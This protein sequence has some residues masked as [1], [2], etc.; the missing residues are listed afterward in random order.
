MAE[1]EVV[2]WYTT[3]GKHRPIYA[4]EDRDIKYNK[5]LHTEYD[6]SDAINPNPKEETPMTIVDIKYIDNM[7]GRLRK[8]KD[9][10]DFDAI[11]HR[12]RTDL[13]KNISNDQTRASMVELLRQAE[14]AR[15]KLEE[16]EKL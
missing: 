9:L 14:F 3:N 7:N 15:D 13:S 8:A 4:D 1:R 5:K 10:K 12:L 2:A 11:I 6:F 16:E